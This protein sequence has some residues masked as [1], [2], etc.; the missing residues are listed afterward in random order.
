[1]RILALGAH[2]DDIEIGCA[3]SLARQVRAG[4]DV[5]LMIMTTGQKGGDP[6]I[7]TA[8]QIESAGILQATDVMWGNYDD[9]RLS[10]DMDKLVSD[11]EDVLTRIRPDFFFV[12]HVDDSHQ[13]HRTLCKAAISASRNMKNVLFYEVPTTHNFSPSVYVDIHDTMDTKINS[14]LAHRSQI[15]KTNIEGLSIVDIARSTAIFRGIQARVSTAE[16]FMP[17]RLFLDFQ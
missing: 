12:N 2:P 15:E 7:R 5:Y 3:G 6:D 4:N 1:M 13:D 10:A 14:L 9:T 16:G 17:L 11:I 8:E